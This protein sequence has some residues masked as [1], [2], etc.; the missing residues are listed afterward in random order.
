MTANGGVRQMKT[1]AKR[2]SPFAAGRCADH[3]DL[4]SQRWVV[5]RLHQRAAAPINSPD[6]PRGDAVRLAAIGGSG[7]LA[8][9]GRGFPVVGNTNLSSS[10]RVVGP[11]AL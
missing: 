11:A 7:D 6:R 4:R 9:G 10:R 3:A 8:C 1:K 2:A 5:G